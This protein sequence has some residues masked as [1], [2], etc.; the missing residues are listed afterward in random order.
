MNGL[1]KTARR[2]QQVLMALS[3][4][5]LSACPPHPGSPTGGGGTPDTGVP[6][7][8][9]GT[10]DLPAAAADGASGDPAGA[11]P[12]DKIAFTQAAGCS[13]DGS[14]EF[15]IPKG[16]AA[17]RTKVQRIAST[18]TC[19]PGRG[20]AGCDPDRQDLCFFPTDA[21]TCKS[22]HGALTE[23]AW[24]QHCQLVTLPQVPRIVHTFFE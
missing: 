5:A 22:P 8:L 2:A 20:R 13:N 1:G 6:R 10:P 14:N 17:T 7:D 16:D 11:C 24:A 15:C 18:V 9:A 21:S 23:T 19:S 12:T 3:L 4:F